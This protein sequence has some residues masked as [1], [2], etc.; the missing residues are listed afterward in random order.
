[1]ERQRQIADEPD[2]FDEA[3]GDLGLRIFGLGWF[4]LFVFGLG[5]GMFLEGVEEV[6]F[7]GL[8]EVDDERG[9]LSMSHLS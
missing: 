5:K 7:G 4:G 6:S 8:G 3:V 9:K 1:M 2:L